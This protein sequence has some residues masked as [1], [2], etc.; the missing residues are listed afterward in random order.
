MTR[1]WRNM[2]SGLEDCTSLQTSPQ[3]CRTYEHRRAIVK[4]FCDQKNLTKSFFVLNKTVAAQLYVEHKYKFIYCEVP[5]VG[6]SNWKRIILLLNESLGF[7]IDSLRH[8]NIH[9]TH[10][11]IKLSSY[12]LSIQKQLLENYT[13]VMITRDPLERVV[14]AYRDKFIRDKGIYYSKTIANAIKKELRNNS[15]TTEN[16][17]FE[18]FARYIVLH[19]PQYTDTHWKPMYN[20]CDP[21]QIQYDII[22]KLKTIKQ[23]ADFILKVIGA[24]KKLRY[25]EIKYSG[26]PR[27]NDQIR[28]QY[29]ETLPPS[30]FRQLQNFY[31]VD[32]D[33]FDYKYYKETNVK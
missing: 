27:T 12:P 28:R 17:T 13:K 10:L 15:N 33:M 31:S 32:F 18:E 21:C 14:S 30:L 7:T 26:D 6:C 8:Y 9:S 3:N 1:S 20:L 5:K 2:T 24:P 29:L 16:I 25:P 19:N 22:G 23:D 11:L 4:S